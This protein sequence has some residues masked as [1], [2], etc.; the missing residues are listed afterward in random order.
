M[1]IFLGY[2]LTYLYLFGILGL[3]GLLKKIFNISDNSSRK[4]VHVMVSFAWVIMFYFFKYSIHNIIPPITF[5]IINYIS[6]KN[7]TFKM[8]EI[9][10]K[11]EKSLGTVYYAVSI[12]LLSLLSVIN[13]KFMIPYGIGVF[14]MAFGD[15]F[16]AIVGRFFEKNNIKLINNK[17]LFG[18]L[19]SFILSLVVVVILNVVFNVNYSIFAIFII[20][21]SSSLL[22]LISPK[23][24]DNLTV[25]IVTAFIAY[26]LL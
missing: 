25:P 8:M 6:Y 22:E 14:C 3:T 21:I 19:T 26:L 7:D 11:K 10:N 16:A 17:T 13:N 18:S 12:F 1:N 9:H 2:F 4:V 23:G 20:S 15:G 24:T 5:I